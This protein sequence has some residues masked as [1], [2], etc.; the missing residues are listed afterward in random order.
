MYF[1]PIRCHPVPPLNKT[2]GCACL[3]AGPPLSEIKR[4]QPGRKLKSWREKSKNCHEQ[5]LISNGIDVPLTAAERSLEF[6]LQSPVDA[7]GFLK[8]IT[9][10]RTRRDKLQQ[11]KLW[12]SSQPFMSGTVFASVDIERTRLSRFG[13][14]TRVSQCRCR[15]TLLGV[16]VKASFFS[17]I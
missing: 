7:L 5:K 9:V 15:P 8:N 11:T 14:A 1:C 13:D 12:I 6:P 3:A 2:T 10:Y 4:W 17:I 16:S